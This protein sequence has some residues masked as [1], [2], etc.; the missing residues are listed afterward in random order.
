MSN[1]PCQCGR[2]IQDT[3][4]LCSTCADQLREQLEKIAD[5]WGDLEQALMEREPG[6]EKGRTKNGMKAVGTTINA[7]AMDARRACTD[8]VWF[9]VQV[10]RDDLDTLG[11]PFTPPVTGDR[12]QDQTPTLARWIAQ[13]HIPHLTHTT[14][15]E[16]AEEGAFD[17]RRAED[18]T[19]RVCEVGRRRKVPTGLPCEGHGTSEAGGRV[20]CTGVMEAALTDQMPDLVCSVDPSHRIPPDVWSRQGWKRAPV[21]SEAGARRLVRRLRA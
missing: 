11:R 5:R 8:V 14:S 6:G 19:Y 7:A 17:V 15:R 16:T 12:S 9:I 2:P 13:W 21:V 3:A 10:I 4:N 18:A 1:E 20:A